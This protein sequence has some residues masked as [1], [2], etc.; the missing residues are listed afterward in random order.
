M[1]VLHPANETLFARAAVRLSE[2]E[3]LPAGSLLY[4]GLIE[5]QGI[6]LGSAA[7]VRASV[8]WAKQ[9]A[10]CEARSMIPTAEAVTGA[11]LLVY[12][13]GH[14][15]IEIIGEE[16][17]ALIHT[18]SGAA[19]GRVAL[20]EQIGDTL[21]LG[22]VALDRGDLTLKHLEFLARATEVCSSRVA[23]AVDAQLVPLAIERGW[24]PQLLAKRAAAAIIA[25][26][27]DGAA[28]RAENAKAAADV[29]L[30]PTQDETARLEAH[31]D[32]VTLVQMMDAIDARAAQLA[33]DGAGLPVGVRRF[34]ALADLVLGE[35]AAARPNVEVV[36]TMDLMTWLG[37]NAQPGELSGYG[38]ISPETAREL[39]QDA[40]FRRLIT[41]PLTAHTLD[42][43]T[44]RYRPSDPLRRFVEARDQTCRFPGCSRRA[45]RCDCDHITEADREFPAAGGPTDRANLHPL[46]RRHHN[47][48]TAKLWHVD[49]NPDGTEVWTS[50]LGFTHIKRAASYP[51]EL[52]QPPD[53][54]PAEIID[55]IPESD[56]D[57]PYPGEPL[58]AA[59]ALTDAEFEQ[60]LDA[61]DRS[62]GNLADR[63]YDTL[64]NAGLIA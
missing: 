23:R 35:P 57:P 44:S 19:I 12:A 40:P 26:D 47:L 1:A 31:G 13:S 54:A 50:P 6:P 9:I 4:A 36:L 42:L 21:P 51:L 8:L 17:A 61:V 64:R 15:A 27:P 32:A 24:T 58:P 39:A 52:L 33:A 20:V 49:V 18:S 10:H 48:K 2:L 11:D 29:V 14:R 59:P 5:L 41:D 43:G 60:F 53:D 62:W 34:N 7:A 56:P 3:Q 22:W 37:L 30:Y 55:R 25:I 16:L 28:E 45:I 63:A 38:P 46:C